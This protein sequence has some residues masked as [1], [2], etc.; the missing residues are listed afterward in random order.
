MLLNSCSPI[1][2]CLFLPSS[3]SKL[4]LGWNLTLFSGLVARTGLSESPEEDP[5]LLAVG[6]H[7]HYFFPRM[8]LWFLTGTDEPS[9][10]AQGIHGIQWNHIL[11]ED[12]YR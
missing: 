9:L 10:K 1:G 11:W 5:Y 6:K 8:E 4:G 3:C 12:P 2:I 7:P